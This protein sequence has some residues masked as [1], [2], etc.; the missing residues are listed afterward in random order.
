M[1]RFAHIQKEKHAIPEPYLLPDFS[2]AHFKQ[3]TD[4]TEI[5]QNAKYG[6]PI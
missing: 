2:P 5:L 6:I 4:G 3:L 1:E